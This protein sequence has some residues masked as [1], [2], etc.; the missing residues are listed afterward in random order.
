MRKLFTERH[1]MNEP[2]VKDKLSDEHKKALLAIINADIDANL[3][4]EAFSEGCP[5]NRAN[6]IGCDLNKLRIAL[7]VY[8]VIWPRDWPIIDHELP[9]EPEL[10]D[11]I[12]FLYEHAALPHAYV[13][14]SF[15]GHDH[16]SYD[17]DP[18]REKFEVGINRFFERNG[19]AFELR[20]GQLTRLAPTGLHEALASQLFR[21]GDA[22][23][24]RLLEASREKFLNR[25]LETRKEG[26]EK[27]WDAWERLKTLENGKDKKTQTK[28]ILDKA[29]AE[30]VLR[31]RL[32]SEAKELNM[33]GND[34]MIRH[35]EVGKPSVRNSEQVDYLFHRMFA[36]IQLLL[37][38]SGRG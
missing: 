6:S 8:K 36:M 2:R 4:G 33:L 19:I 29:S 16:L 37:K 23:L 1:G 32:E 10:F 7:S 3:F 15:F 38:S 28:A 35:T 22:D 30:P 13:H 34:L 20:H 11:L 9:T 18:G 21:T 5:D 26:L 31:E 14:H 17:V 27:L 12:E 24:D 25:S